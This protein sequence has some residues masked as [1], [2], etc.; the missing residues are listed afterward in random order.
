MKKRN[1]RRIFKLL[2]YTFSGILL[3]NIFMMNIFMMLTSFFF[4][5]FNVMLITSHP[6][7]NVLC[8][9]WQGFGSLSQKGNT[10]E[11]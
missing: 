11:H 5:F 2:V 10:Q 3:P 7:E 1:M 8:H 4:F 9:I 6:S